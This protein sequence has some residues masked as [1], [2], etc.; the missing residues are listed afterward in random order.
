MSDLKKIFPTSIFPRQA[1]GEGVDYYT[2]SSMESRRTL[3]ID[4]AIPQELILGDNEDGL[5]F[6]QAASHRLPVWE[7]RLLKHIFSSDKSIVMV[8]GGSGCGKTSSARFLEEYCRSALRQ[9]NDCRKAYGIETNLLRVELNDLPDTLTKETDDTETQ[10]MQTRETLRSLI[11]RIDATLEFLSERST[12]ILYHKVFLE[13]RSSTTGTE[14]SA[15]RNEIRKKYRA[16]KDVQTDY[17][18]EPDKVDIHAVDRILGGIE[19]QHERLAATLL[20][21]LEISKELNRQ[22]GVPLSLLIDNIDRCPDYVQWSVLEKFVSFVKAGSWD[23]LRVILF[24]RL[25]S[26]A[27]AG[28]ALN[29]AKETLSFESP[30]PSSLAF[31]RATRFLIDPS[32]YPDFTNLAEDERREVQARVL[33]FWRQL[34]DQP[35]E[36]GSLLSGLAG[37]N[38]RNAYHFSRNWCC[39]PRLPSVGQSM[40]NVIQDSSA[41]RD[42][43]MYTFIAHLGEAFSR[44]IDHN[45]D[46]SHL[47]KVFSNIPPESTQPADSIAEQI[48]HGISRIFLS[49]LEDH[50]LVQSRRKKPLVD[51]PIRARVFM[52]VSS[53]ISQL[54]GDLHLEERLANALRPIR[55]AVGRARSRLIA[56]EPSLALRIMSR[57]GIRLR[58]ISKAMFAEEY[59]A[60]N[61]THLESAKWLLDYFISHIRKSLGGGHIRHEGTGRDSQENRP[62]IL[63]RVGLLLR[64][65]FNANLSR[66]EA[67]H[68]LVSPDSA[69]EHTENSAVN[70]F[71]SEDKSICPVGLETLA[72]L[73]AETHGTTTARLLKFLDGLG[74]SRSEIQYALEE[75]VRINRR[76]IF[77]GIRD[78]RT[79]I[80]KWLK[81]LHRIVHIS[82]SGVA[83]L[84]D[85]ISN[86]AYFQW[87]TLQIEEIRTRLLE[88]YSMNWKTIYSG[89]LVDRLAAALYC[90]RYLFDNEQLR[91]LNGSTNRSM[92]SPTDKAHPVESPTTFIFFQALIPY[93]STIQVTWHQRQR[94]EGHP[95]HEIVDLA[96]EWLA[97]GE[98]LLSAHCEKFHSNV[99]EYREVLAEARRILAEV[100]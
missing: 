46:V 12:K 1:A 63:G 80:A 31:H 50:R 51:D 89:P 13:K 83:Y 28:G 24:V 71:S 48:A 52:S 66:F 2:S 29:G 96:G 56:E 34:A 85:V 39:S 32:Q 87:A 49:I 37:T 90:F 86:P 5:S 54:S 64:T 76:V 100:G 53:S 9:N 88:N 62:E 59:Q 73:Y 74:F 4:S 72:F 79:S 55:I 78:Y 92:Y 35:G 47:R 11:R 38:V 82:S 57:L 33:L 77:S 41:F 14:F 42:E 30:I 67:T 75:M 98:I 99:N 19:H 44:A 23:T 25:S 95:D 60:P 43:L 10:E 68:I 93:A 65:T 20:L 16:V 94:H 27:R 81:D 15:V 26:S 91:N 40:A 36:F 61:Q 17:R 21:L 7:G 22:A 3:P 58:A 45:T 97:F 6:L 8:K 69:V 70:V 18:I 84:L